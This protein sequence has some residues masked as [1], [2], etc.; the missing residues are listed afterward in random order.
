MN[1]VPRDGA[2]VSGG[3]GATTFALETDSTFWQQLSVGILPGSGYNRDQPAELTLS[4]VGDFVSG[5]VGI[6]ID[7]LALGQ[8]AL[9]SNPNGTEIEIDL[10]DPFVAELL[11]LAA[12]ASSLD[13]SFSLGAGD[14]FQFATTDDIDLN[15][16]YTGL[17][18]GFGIA[19][20]VSPVVPEMP[21]WAMLVL[22]LAGLGAIGYRGSRK[23]AAT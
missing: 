4:T 1:G 5:D 21:T 3:A 23:S 18:Y 7:G 10:P 20:F 19:T 13:V 11:A 14:W 2:I 9:P 6:A 16:A 17:L 12:G 15:P 8:F 22:G